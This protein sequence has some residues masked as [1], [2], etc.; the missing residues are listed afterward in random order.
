ML[1]AGVAIIGIVVLWFLAI[2]AH[3]LLEDRGLW[4]YFVYAFL[5]AGA[6]YCLIRFI[7]WAWE[8]PM[9]FVG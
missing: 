8:T 1:E 2:T 6:L 7:R 9:P 3:G 4:Q 5:G